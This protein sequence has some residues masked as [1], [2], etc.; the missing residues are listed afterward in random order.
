MFS[1]DG[2]RLVT[3]SADDKTARVWDAAS[4][5]PLATLQV[6]KGGVW[7]VV[8]SPDGQRRV[9]ASVDKTARVWDVSL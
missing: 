9:T 8:L 4:G 3:A 1:P 5:Q 6:H 2:H 7:C